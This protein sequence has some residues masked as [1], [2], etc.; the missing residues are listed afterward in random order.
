M[1]TLQVFLEK[2]LFLLAQGCCLKFPFLQ[3]NLV[4]ENPLICGLRAI[5]AWKVQDRKISSS[6]HTILCFIFLCGYA[7]KVTLVEKQNSVTNFEVARCCS[8]WCISTTFVWSF[9]EDGQ[10]FAVNY[11]PTTNVV[12]YKSVACHGSP[13]FVYV[14]IFYLPFSR[15]CVCRF[16]EL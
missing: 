11:F 13:Q 2:L 9:L 1:W 10:N 15:Y 4:H 7:H 16:L 5:L 6:N 8:R 12:C 3:K 14:E